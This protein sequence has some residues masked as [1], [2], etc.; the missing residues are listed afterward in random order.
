VS[1]PHSDRLAKTLSHA[2]AVRDLIVLEEVV[3]SHVV[4]GKSGHFL[5]FGALVSVRLGRVREIIRQVC[6][7][8]GVTINDG[9]LSRDHVDLFVEIPPH[10]SVSD[11]VRRAKGRS[12]RK[13]QQEFEH[14]RIASGEALG[15][16]MECRS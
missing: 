13:V 2:I 15:R 12:L 7:E 6:S 16:R 11:F 8:M 9:A 3:C 14:I 4:N 5:G 10:V 1:Q